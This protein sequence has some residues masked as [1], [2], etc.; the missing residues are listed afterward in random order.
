MRKVGT[1]ALM[2]PIA[3]AGGY[4]GIRFAEA[5]N[6]AVGVGGAFAVGVIC[7][8]AYLVFVHEDEDE[9]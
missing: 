1:A 4:I 9:D 6:E 2:A 3:A 7:A 5:W 8:L